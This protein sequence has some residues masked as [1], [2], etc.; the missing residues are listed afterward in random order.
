MEQEGCLCL[1]GFK[2]RQLE[3]DCWAWAVTDGK[4]EGFG[5]RRELNGSE[6]PIDNKR[7]QNKLPA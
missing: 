6:I 4:I 2:S 5:W 7:P 3:S 1:V